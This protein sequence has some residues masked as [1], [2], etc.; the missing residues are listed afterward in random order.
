MAEL[1]TPLAIEVRGISKRFGDETDGLLALDSCSFDVAQG[2]FVS[3]VGPSGCG[4]STM[5]RL[6]ADLLQPSTG[7]IVVNQQSARD[8]R[9]ARDIGVVFQNP[10]LYQ[11]RSVRRNVELPL[12]VMNL[13]KEE[14]RR[15]ADQML[16]LVGLEEFADGYPWELSGGMQQRVSIARAL[17]FSP[18]ILLMDEPFGALDE[19]T[20]ER[21]NAELQRIWS[22][23]NATVLFITHSIAEAVFLSDRVMVM[24]PRPGKMDLTTEIPLPRPRGRLRPCG[25]HRALPTNNR[26][27][28]RTQGHSCRLRRGRGFPDVLRIDSAA[29]PRSDVLG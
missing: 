25:R 16:E 4:K 14:R 8:A 28:D 10:V 17:S 7:S 27:S 5:L 11:W 19:L 15:L 29:A 9:L 12:E 21:M 6:I 18:D 22:T 1:V 20:R 26:G 13:R 24:S 2:E 3:I 23:T